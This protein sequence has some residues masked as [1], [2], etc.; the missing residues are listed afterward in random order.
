LNP[1]HQDATGAWLNGWLPLKLKNGM[2][3]K[4]LYVSILLLACH[5]FRRVIVV[6][7]DSQGELYESIV[8]LPALT[9]WLIFLKSRGVGISCPSWEWFRD[10][11]TLAL[12]TEPGFKASLHVDI[13]LVHC[14]AHKPIW[15]WRQT[16]EFSNFWFLIFL[17]LPRNSLLCTD[18][19]RDDIS[20]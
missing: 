16:A 17:S 4:A 20:A 11:Q 8:L 19:P 5:G 13:S 14:S 6:L 15:E 18:S 10:L 9:S 1:V 2:P 7:K 12:H 3:W